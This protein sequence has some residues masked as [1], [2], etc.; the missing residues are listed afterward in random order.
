MCPSDCG[1]CQ[2]FIVTN[3]ATASLH[4]NVDVYCPG[5][6]VL[7]GGGC[8]QGDLPA[9]S[10]N[11]AITDSRPIG[12]TGWHCRTRDISIAT[13]RTTTAYAICLPSP[14]GYTRVSSSITA[15]GHYNVDV[16][17]TG[18]RIMTGG[19]CGQG[20]LP[21]ASN[22]VAITDSRPIGTTGWHC[23]TRDVAIGTTRTT[24]A[25]VMCADPIPG[26]TTASSSTTAS[27][28]YNVDAYCP[29]GRIMIGGGCGQGDVSNS[30]A[31]TDSGPIGTTGWHCR[32][33]DVS[34]GTSRT[35]TAYVICAP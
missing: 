7:T 33:R 28:H 34:T 24:T 29:G 26:Y 17:C 20:D 16:Y 30:T 12:T 4:Y 25:Y 22:N 5:G 13:T 10:N 2:N 35:T 23:R 18:G 31:I 21:A 8:T 3:S 27:G 6:T 32:T 19:G 11:V 9:A 15:S 1:Q 14:S